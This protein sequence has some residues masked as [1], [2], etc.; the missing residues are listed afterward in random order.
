[1]LRISARRSSRRATLPMLGAALFAALV[2]ALPSF[3]LSPGKFE[4]GDGN[5]V[6]GT[7]GN[8]DWESSTIDRRIKPDQ[9]TGANDDSL[10]ANKENDEVPQ[11]ELGSIP[12]NKS[13]L[14]FFYTGKET[15]EQPT[16][17]FTDFLYLGWS[18]VQDPSGTTNLDFE[19]NQSNTLSSNGVTYLRTTNDVLI[20]YD[21]SRGGTRPEIRI[22]KW[23]ASKEWG[24]AALLSATQ[25]EAGINSVAAS[26]PLS[27]LTTPAQPT[28]FSPRTFGEAAINLQASGIF[29][30]NVCTNFGHAFVKSRSSDSFTA[31]LKDFI[32][33]VN[34]GLNSCPNSTVTLKKVTSGGSNLGG[35]TLAL[36]FDAN[37]NDQL[38][39]T[40]PQVGSDCLT[41]G[42][43]GIG[44]CTFTVSVSGTY[45]G[46]EED[47]PDGYIL[48][49][50]PQTVEVTIDRTATNFPLTFSNSPGPGDLTVT[51]QDPDGN[52]LDGAVFALYEDDNGDGTID[53]PEDAVITTKTTG[54]GGEP[55]GQAVFTSLAPGTYVVKET[56]APPGYDLPAD[57]EQ[58]VTIAIADNNDVTKT[59]TDPPTKGS[60]TVTKTNA[61]A[62]STLEGATF[63]L[64]QDF[65]PLGG[66]P[67]DE[68]TS[69]GTCLT[70]TLGTCTFSNLAIG[71]YIVV[72]TDAPA[73]YEIAD[74]AYQSVTINIDG[75]GP[76]A[77]PAGDQESVSFANEQFKGKI[78]ITKV[79]DDDPAVKLGG[80]DFDVF[81]DDGDT[82]DAYDAADTKVGS[83]TT[84]L[85]SGTCEVTGLDPGKYWAVET[86]APDGYDL[87]ATAADRIK[88]FTIELADNGDVEGLTF[89]DP[90]RFTVITVVC[91]EAGGKLYPSS[92]TLD[93]AGPSTSIGAGDL[94]G[95]GPTEA[96]VC[97]LGGAR[98]EGKH[99]GG[100]YGA[101]VT[102][103]K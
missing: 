22:R 1:M 79:D 68:D 44:T 103:P 55:V 92:V 45:F 60:I 13:D 40:D 39:A 86:D 74:P 3:A 8:K 76:D 52:K 72:E 30:S 20:T 81:A 89:S 29:Q 18:R 41:S 31:T 94:P 17:T 33:P 58:A 82:A 11:L 90:R 88:G 61:D 48:D 96:E 73:G 15:V 57:T 25:A 51:K 35:A 42:T 80:A 95:S 12:N 21:L 65:A 9:P 5:L 47:A 46:V 2:V 38:D 77:D 97:G 69:L 32:A 59:F 63:E 16:G 100:P 85:P 36:Y 49:S 84:G 66:A 67:G 37:G 26:N 62:S 23:L 34:I 102:I 93:G 43:D 54:A 64:F 6:V 10:N 99:F 7:T 24:P 83:C 56:A 78:V 27:A 98:F 87:P 4:G 91:Q 53:P 75:A 19:L 71:D 50:T 14:S 28:S 70:G 101:S